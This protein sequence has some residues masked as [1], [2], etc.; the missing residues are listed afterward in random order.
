MDD[1][2]KFWHYHFIA[3]KTV[4]P[5][6]KKKRPLKDVLREKEEKKMEEARLK[7]EMLKQMEV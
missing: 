2:L 5:T 3:G 7:A 4:L 6:K 1:D